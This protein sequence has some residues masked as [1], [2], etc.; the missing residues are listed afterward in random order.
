M[1]KILIIDDDDDVRTMFRLTLTHFGHT[2]VE[3]RDGKE[4]LKLFESHRPDL[5]ITDIVMPEQEGI[6]LLLELR[7]RPPMPKIIAVSGGGTRDAL[8][9]LRMAKL[10]GANHVLTKPIP[11]ATLVA[12]VDAL[13]SGANEPAATPPHVAT[14]NDRG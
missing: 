13:V 14:D 7:K 2:V 8:E 5:V 11:M 9:Y 12:A 4:G 6:G 10:L 3:A 1:P